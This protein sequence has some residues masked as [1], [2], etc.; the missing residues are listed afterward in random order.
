MLI[1]VNKMLKGLKKVTYERIQQPLIATYNQHFLY[2][3]TVQ[4][5]PETGAENKLRSIKV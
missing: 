1:E 5:S 3:T 2:G 4:L